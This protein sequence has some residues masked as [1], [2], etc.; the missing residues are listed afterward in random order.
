MGASKGRR[1]TTLLAETADGC[2]NGFQTPHIACLGGLLT[3]LG[4]WGF[5]LLLLE[6]TPLEP[7][8]P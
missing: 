7:P 6:E 4:L 1:E 3:L 2:V 8:N 5:L